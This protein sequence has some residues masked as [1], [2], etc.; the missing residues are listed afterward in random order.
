M[1]RLL[2][3]FVALSLSISLAAQQVTALR[4]S[5]T[6]FAFPHFQAARVDQTFGRHVTDSVNIF[7]KDASLCFLQDGKILKA[8]VDPILGF[9]VDSVRYRKVGTQMGRVVAQ[10]GNNMLLCVTTVDMDKLTE[11]TYGSVQA[12]FFDI[13][14]PG[15]QN[16][17]MDLSGQER[18]EDYGYPLKDTFYFLINGQEVLA[19]ESQVKKYVRSDRKKA[20]KA[21]MAD[22]F[23][24]WRDAKNLTQVLDYLQ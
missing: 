11:E 22:R 14:L 6:V 17:F 16:V 10:K 12:G 4:R 1:K 8:F 23:W 5:K 21:L 7:L 19:N 15:S 2:L 3:L 24:S 9:Q 20:W 13:E 18:E